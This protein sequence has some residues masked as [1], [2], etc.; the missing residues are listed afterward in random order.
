[1]KA[2][3][4]VKSYSMASVL[5]FFLM[6]IM[7]V[8]LLTVWSI[9][10]ALQQQRAVD[11]VR[12]HGET[13]A[14][15][16]SQATGFIGFDP[17]VIQPLTVSLKT[18]PNI[19]QVKIVD[20]E[21]VVQASSTPQQIGTKSDLI[22]SYGLIQ[23][24]QNYRLQTNNNS[25]DVLR[26]L[27]PIL[28]VVAKHGRIGT[29]LID[30][31]LDPAYSTSLRE[32]VEI[33]MALFLFSLIITL[34]LFIFVRWRIIRP[35]T[36]LKYGTEKISQGNLD[37]HIQ[38]EFKDEL[39]D[40]A[41]TFNLMLDKL[42]T[43]LVSK[44]YVESIVNSMADMLFVLSTD[45]VIKRVNTRV[46]ALLGYQEAELLGQHIQIFLTQLDID[47]LPIN[48]TNADSDSDNHQE[49]RVKCKDGRFLDIQC[50]F[51]ALFSP[52]QHAAPKIEGIICN[53]L[54]VSMRIQAERD[55]KH[56]TQLLEESNEEI[57]SISHIVAHD[58]RSPLVNIKGFSGEL[59]Y[60]ITALKEVLLKYHAMME[61]SDQDLI[62]E[63][64]NTDITEALGY[65]NSSTMRMDRLINGVLKVSRLGRREFQLEFVDMQSLASK[66]CISLQH[67]V[68]SKAITIELKNL[69]S[70]NS[71]LMAMEQIMGN[72]IDNAIKYMP[73]NHEGKIE[74]SSTKKGDQLVFHVKDNGC[75][76]AEQHVSKLFNL[77]ERLGHTDI[78]GEGLGLAY[79]R[80]LVRQLGG[81]I[82]C[83]SQVGKGSTFSFTIPQG[84]D[85]LTGS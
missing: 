73:I 28:S 23:N 66:I 22:S 51:A 27:T 80:R 59:N 39:G 11:K 32:T 84:A 1:M 10:H 53:A 48:N 36:N 60:S 81:Q 29:I 24:T 50:T 45:L 47:K 9:V 2:N 74:V 52:D 34:S 69:P 46:S 67:Q 7:M 18:E 13:L 49:L 44:L 70:I 56:K 17:E 6:A 42:K 38:I 19:I 68:E 64:L 77:F 62:E 83:E 85:Q 30:I 37:K 75:G 4:T 31:D 40:L 16:F 25:K 82:W 26:I 20:N 79:V 12:L 57:K 21:F 14:T 65:I 71:D 3:F 76:I 63:I 41:N 78:N 15:T 43:S 8:M 33:V 55:L 54:D 58:L 5:G 35:I 72:L 61:K